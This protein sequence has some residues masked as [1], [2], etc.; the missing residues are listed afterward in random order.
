MFWA[1]SGDCAGMLAG[2]VT[3]GWV[4]S[5]SGMFGAGACACGSETCPPGGLDCVFACLLSWPAAAVLAASAGFVGASPS[6]GMPAAV[7][8]ALALAVALAA[9]ICKIWDATGGGTCELV[10]GRA[11][12]GGL[13]AGLSLPLPLSFFALLS[14]SLSGFGG[15][16]GACET[17]RLA[18]SVPLVWLAVSLL[19]FSFEP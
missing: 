7:A 10:C 9:I 6:V 17:V 13:P 2:W 8:L 15:I 14:L 19:L 1:L 18:A 3:G 11:G 4:T 16:T 5:A 12:E